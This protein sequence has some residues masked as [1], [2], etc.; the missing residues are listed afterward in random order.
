MGL[1][2]LERISDIRIDRRLQRITQPE[3]HRGS[4]KVPAEVTAQ[5]RR[6]NAPRHSGRLRKHV[7]RARL[8][9]LQGKLAN[10]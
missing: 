9:C 8:N 7:S 5:R 1:A 4:P 10:T 2:A 6:Q 3:I